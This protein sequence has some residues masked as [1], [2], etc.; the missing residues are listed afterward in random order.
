MLHNYCITSLG[1]STK[2]LRSTFSSLTFFIRNKLAGRVCVYQ[3]IRTF[4]THFQSMPTSNRLSY[5]NTSS[6]VLSLLK[7]NKTIVHLI[8]EL[9]FQNNPV[10]EKVDS[11]LILIGINWASFPVLLE[12]IPEN[13]QIQVGPSNQP[14]D[15]IQLA[16]LITGSWSNPEWQD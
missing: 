4:G 16:S 12:Q 8:R 5:K 1:S 11:C 7:L 14:C 6:K 9:T 15:L 3:T 10:T 2:W 13:F